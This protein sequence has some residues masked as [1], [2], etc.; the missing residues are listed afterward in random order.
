MPNEF[1]NKVFCGDFECWGKMIGGST[2]FNTV[3]YELTIAED[4]IQIR[5]NP[6]EKFG[7]NEWGETIKIKYKTKEIWQSPEFSFWKKYKLD[8]SSS[9]ETDDSPLHPKY[10]LNYITISVSEF[11]NQSLTRDQQRSFD[12]YPLDKSWI[13]FDVSVPYYGSGGPGKGTWPNATVCRTLISESEIKKEK[14]VQQVKVQNDSKKYASILQLIKDEKI[15]DA[16]TEIAKLYFPEKFPYVSELQQKEDAQLKAQIINLLSEKKFDAAINKYN[17][18]NLQETANELKSEMQVALAGYYKTFE[19]PFKDEQL[20]KIINENKAPL[21]KLSPGKY[22]ISSDSEG[23]LLVDGTPIGKKTSPLTKS[24]GRNNQLTVNT[25]AS[26]S[27]KIEQITNNNGAEQILVSTNKPIFE[28][29]KGKLY[30]NVFLGGPG[31]YNLGN[32]QQV[33]VSVVSDIPKNTYRKVQP[34]VIQKTANGIEVNSKMENKILSENK[35]QTRFH[36][37]STKV[38]LITGSLFY[39]GLR[40]FEITQIP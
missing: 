4:G 36:I 18:L 15:E 7:R 38:I 24:F 2:A 27:I 16:K 26:G 17:S 30:K 37:V 35:F 19:Q 8:L 1:K 40:L 31:I 21:D 32:H 20:I 11:N 28:T 13:E 9:N 29:G 39:V 6:S 3:P 34:L 23:N 33:N 10:N 25:S 5:I 22:K 12:S 14:E